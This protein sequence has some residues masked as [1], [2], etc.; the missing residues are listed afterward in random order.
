MFEMF[1]YPG[2]RF[3]AAGCSFRDFMLHFVT[4]MRCVF[5]CHSSNQP[6]AASR[7]AE[8]PMYAVNLRTVSSRLSLL[9]VVFVFG[10]PPKLSKSRLV[11]CAALKNKCLVKVGSD[12]QDSIINLTWMIS[13]LA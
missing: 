13:L 10:Q 3:Q 6:L 9:N 8:A 11:A 12:K 1:I 2:G 5:C 4:F 7:K